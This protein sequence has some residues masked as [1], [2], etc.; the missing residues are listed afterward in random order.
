MK[1]SRSV[2]IAA[3][4]A[5]FFFYACNR[6]GKDR[7]ETPAFNPMIAAF[8]SGII[9]S[10]STVKVRFAEPVADSV[11][12]NSTVDKGTMTLDPPVDGTVFFIDRQTI[13]FRPD[14]RFRQ[15]TAYDVH[16]RLDKLFP[17]ATTSKTFDFRFHTIE[18]Y[19]G[20]ELEGF[21]PYNDYAPKMNYLSAR[22]TTA[23]IA[24]PEAIQE[25]IAV[26]QEGNELPVRWEHGPDGKVHQF[27]IDSIQR[28]DRELAVEIRYDGQAISSAQQGKEIFKVPALGDFKVISHRLVQYPEQHVLLSFSDPL[29]KD[30]SLNG[31]VRLSND[32]DMRFIVEGNMVRAY[33]NVRQNGSRTLFVEP[34][35][36]NTAGKRLVTGQS[37][38]IV[39]E[40]IKPSVELLGNGV[41]IP[42]SDEV[43]LPFKAVNLRALD[44]KVIRIY[45][46]NIAQFLQV[47][48]LDGNRELKRAGRLVLKKTISLVADQPVNYG[49]WNTFSLNLTELVKTE[50]GAIYRVELNFRQIHSMYACKDEP[51]AVLPEPEDNYD[52]IEE[53]DLSYWDSYEN[54]YSDWDYYDYEGYN[55]EDREDP[56]KPAYYGNRRAVSRNILSSNLG[57]IAK[58]GAGEQLHV[59]VTDL[60]RA[61]AVPG[62][63]VKVYNF[64]QQLLAEAP[65]NNAGMA[66]IDLD[67]RPFLVV[68]EQG[69]QKGYL[70]MVDGASLSYSMFDVSG[71]VVQ[72]GIKGFLYGER[73]VWRPGDS[74]YINLVLN[75][76][77]NPLPEGHPVAFELKDPQGKIA[78]RSIAPGNTTGF[79][80]FHTHT[81]SNAP[82]GRYTVTASA[83]GVS[84]T[85]GLQV[86]T[87][88]PNRLRIALSFDQGDTIYPAKGAV[89]G[90]LSGEWLTGATAIGLRAEV[91]V[92]LRSANTAFK[93]FE[94]Y[95]FSDPAKKID[96]PGNTFWEGNTDQSGQARF[97]RQLNI[98]GEAP[99]ML[100]AIF[101]TRLFE[102]SGEF[103]I[104]QK[105]VTCS[106]YNTYVGIKTPAG[107]KRGM[108]LTDTAHKVDV[109]TLDAEGKPVEKLGLEVKVYKLSWRW[110]WD[111][112]YENLA[113]Y[114]GSSSMAPVYESTINTKK[115]TGT[116]NF[117]INYPEWGR[118]L[119]MVRDQG[120]HSAA[121]IVYVDWPG[122]AGRAGKGDP[123][124][125]SVLAFSS[126][127]TTYTV[128]ETA[129][130]TIPSS[131]KGRILVSLENGSGVLRQEWIETS[132]SET[133]YQLEITPEMTPNI[134]LFAS[135]IQPHENTENDLPIRM[136]GVIPIKVEDPATR[137]YPQ[138]EMPDE[139]RPE[140][141]VRIEVTEK[142]NKKMTYTIAMVDEG[143]L[144][145]T[146]FRTPD[147]WAAFFAKE[148]LGVKT[149]D[150]FDQVLGAFGGRIDGI[151]SI[152]GG[153]DES[154]AGAKDANRF[155][156]M[157]EF[158]GPFTLDGKRNVHEITIPNYI[159]SVRTMLIAGSN[160]A[161]GHTEKTTPVKQ[162]LMLLA[163]LPRVLGPGEEVALPVNVFV[164]EEGISQVE[165]EISTNDMLIP[166][167]KKKTVAFSETGDKIIGFMLKTPEKTG[168]GKVHIEAGSG[169]HRASYDIEL[170]IRSSNPPVTSFITAAVEPSE[171]FRKEFNYVGM[172]GT[173]DLMLE[174]SNIPPIDFGRRLKYLLRYPH[175]CIEQVSSAAFPQLFLGD[176]VEL[177]ETAAKKAENNVRQA[178]TSLTAFQLSDGGFSYWPGSVRASDWGTSYAGHFLLEAKEKGFGVPEAILQNWKRYQRKAARRWSIAGSTNTYEIRQEQLLRPTGSSPW[179]SPET[180]RSDP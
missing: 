156:P 44:L 7:L 83:G 118:Y 23:D 112:S 105:T 80:S 139:L 169:K 148:A 27:T 43:K 11:E 104:D 82:T 77:E 120:G 71:T 176:V 117:R 36:R 165:L 178:I 111:A 14:G 70:R 155:P 85:K 28:G 47:N 8:T 56:C 152:G 74:I 17:K 63:T 68:A 29:S 136:F 145:L 26:V 24:D 38:E 125:A 53:E 107:D 33:P 129:L 124:A 168:V 91:E 21:R 69:G 86:E 166:A 15:G 61:T 116:F 123:D 128:G 79:Y 131:V 35:I 4:T 101:T 37:F 141:T 78:K 171:T 6:P 81:A 25:V 60:L 32:T 45:E 140:S 62:A 92:L 94:A 46:D 90:S 126:D 149:W 84:F 143:L 180:Q 59:T 87:I 66:T 158:I 113:S 93:G 162:P 127:K 170:N 51:P 49:Q 133:K 12:V 132:G 109:V 172:A 134:Y 160:E 173:N 98:G 10:E 20:I 39:F 5:L 157:V 161:Y 122:W 88:K 163:T 52:G 108:L 64:Q 19:L 54:Y 65:T 174:V 3:A 164:M 142:Y 55:W 110:W 167:E 58:Y 99:G 34:G 177:T 121:K 89:S 72:K 97:S 16:V 41:I 138:L 1:S 135:L 50:P 114:M 30:Q 106:P 95:T 67:A 175:G 137:L 103:S 2:I 96:R 13:G 31:L 9:S 154:G 76:S 40:E 42:T 100:H 130:V 115:G 73:G 159:G 151:Y 146:R 102:R 18:Q 75:D 48:Q 22:L 153:M 147:P 144:D 179:H 57:L 150:M 119:V